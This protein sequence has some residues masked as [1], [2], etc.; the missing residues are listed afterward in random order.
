MNVRC[1]VR[2]L[3][4]VQWLIRELVERQPPSS[5]VDWSF[6]GGSPSCCD[7]SIVGAKFADQDCAYC[8]S[9]RRSIVVVQRGVLECYSFCVSTQHVPPDCASG[10]QQAYTNTTTPA[11]FT[12]SL[13]CQSVKNIG[14]T[15]FSG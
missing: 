15:V 5:R 6:P 3:S 8:A 13:S 12:L 14:G 2:D 10:K 11:F 1:C 4:A 9:F 7:L